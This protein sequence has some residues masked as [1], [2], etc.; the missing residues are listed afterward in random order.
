[1]AQLLYGSGLRMME[2]LRLRVKDILF[3]KYQII[4]RDGKGEKDRVTMLPEIAVEGLRRQIAVAR[5][6]LERDLAEGRGSVWLPY[7][8][9]KKYPNASK[10][11]A[12]QY[13]FPAHKLSTDARSG[14]VHRH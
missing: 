11:F 10:E 6:V 14:N 3:D 1:M 7:A 12:W 9:A 13:V 2:G 8:L 5:D 4:V